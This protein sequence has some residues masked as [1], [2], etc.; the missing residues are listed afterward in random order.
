[1]QAG[2]RRAL[3]GLVLEPVDAGTAGGVV[4]CEP[5]EG[6]DGPAVGARD[7]GRG[8]RHRQR[9]TGERHPV[10]SCVRH[11]RGALHPRHCTSAATR[12]AQAL[13]TVSAMVQD[14]GD[15]D[16]GVLGRR[17]LPPEDRLWRHPS[18]LA[19]M[20]PPEPP[21]PSSRSVRAVALAG[22]V[23][24]AALAT[25]VLALSGTL[26]PRVVERPVVEQVALTPVVSSPLLRDGDDLTRVVGRAATALV[27]LEVRRG[28]SVSTASG[29]VFRDDGLV[30]TAAHPLR[31]ADAVFVVLADGRRLRGEVTGLDEVTDIAVVDVDAQDLPVAVLSE[32]PA[33]I[34]DLVVALGAADDSG[35]P[36]ISAGLV[37][38]LDQ[39]LALPD[40]PVLHGLVE[41]DA[42]V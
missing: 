13:A 29:V 20:L 39:R 15:D 38:A 40:G 22:V 10:L 1:A 4:A 17:P 12:S 16:E 26:A 30:L 25:S 24:G 35:Q 32:A 19:A 27:R 9:V 33:E 37:T 5:G 3:V 41:T 2:Q 18:E 42:D 28:G 11:R 36:S 34:G 14:D 23:A 7:E 6:D 8:S 21:P 31:G